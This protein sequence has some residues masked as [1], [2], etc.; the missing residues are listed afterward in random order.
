MSGLLLVTG[1]DTG[2]GKTV[3]TCAILRALQGRGEKPVPIKPVET[4]CVDLDQPEDALALSAAAPGVP[5]GVV[6]PVRYRT[7]AAPA[8]AARIEGR[9]HSFEGLVEHVRAIR[10]ANPRVILE[11]AGGLLVP[12][13]GGKTYADIA[14]ELGASLLIVARNALGTINHTSLTLEAAKSRGIP[15]LAVVLNAVSTPDAVFIDHRAELRALWPGV[16]ILG[17]T[18][19]MKNLQPTK[20]SDEMSLMKFFGHDYRY[21]IDIIADN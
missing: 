20:M 9:A 15:V 19:R 5:L 16:P 4:G 14:V 8:T 21:L 7:P 17:P 12:L 13:D 2:V 1:T 10:A 11:G 3:V 6:C 18:S